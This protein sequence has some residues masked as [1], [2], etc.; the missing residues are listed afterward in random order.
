[1]R[2]RLA[3]LL[4]LAFSATPA[5][6]IEILDRGTP[7]GLALLRADP[8]RTG[9]VGRP[10]AEASFAAAAAEGEARAHA[11][12]RNLSAICGAHPS[13]PEIRPRDVDEGIGR[14]LLAAD[15]NGD[16]FVTPDEARGHLA[17]IRNP[18]ARAASALALA[19]AEQGLGM[20]MERLAWTAYA[21][22]RSETEEAPI[23]LRDLVSGNREAW[24]RN[25]AWL[26][27][28]F[29]ERGDGRGALRLDAVMR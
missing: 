23:A 17:G 7:A 1:M 13:T 29:R 27:E 24:R 18:D 11:T 8:G 2:P 15:A 4:A 9:A 5:A 3:C 12:W 10:A 25:A 28:A 6:S 21:N 16:G 26:D 14:E 20:P 22:I 19:M